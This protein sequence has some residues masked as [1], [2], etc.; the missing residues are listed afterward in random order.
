MGFNR[1]CPLCHKIE[2]HRSAMDHPDQIKA[3]NDE[4]VELG[5]IVGPFE[6]SPTPNLHFP[7]MSRPKPNSEVRRV[8]VDLSWPKNASIN[9]GVD[10]HGYLNSDF[11]LTFPTI[12]HLTAE[13]K[14]IGKGAN[15]YTYK[16]DVSRAFCHLKM[17]HF[18]FDLLGL[19]WHGVYIDTCLP[20]GSRHRSQFF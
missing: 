13:L 5:A 17:D 16:V 12:D 20:F 9:D 2:N 11:T 8:I 1:D 6:S 15:I 10:K 18:D 3:Y 7:L 4:E 14:C 19:N